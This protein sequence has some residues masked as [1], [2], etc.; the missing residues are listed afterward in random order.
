MIKNIELMKMAV[1]PK[2]KTRLKNSI[3]KLKSKIF[4]RKPQFSL[5]AELDIEEKSET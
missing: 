5:P 3:L 1:K 4:N 2:L